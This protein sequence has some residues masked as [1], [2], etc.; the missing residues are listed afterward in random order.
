MFKPCIFTKISL[1]CNSVI[2]S[3]YLWTLSDSTRPRYQ[4]RILNTYEKSW[5]A[6]YRVWNLCRIVSLVMFHAG[7][8]YYKSYPN[9]NSYPNSC[10]NLDPV[11]RVLAS[12]PARSLPTMQLGRSSKWTSS[13]VQAFANGWLSK[14]R[15]MKLKRIILS[16]R[17]KSWVAL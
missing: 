4:K 11:H 14:T 1:S 9:P 15:K 6:L 13:P 17:I 5:T 3:L 12:T 10:T 8:I 7:S 2:N 16:F